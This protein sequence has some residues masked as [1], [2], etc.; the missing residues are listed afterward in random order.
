[1]QLNSHS[2]TLS[3]LSCCTPAHASPDDR[4]GLRTLL[5]QIA[6]RSQNVTVKGRIQ[7]VKGCKACERPT[8]NRHTATKLST[9]RSTPGP[10]ANASLSPHRYDADADVVVTPLGLVLQVSQQVNR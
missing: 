2:A 5:S 9:A 1:M 10:P 7:R 8:P 4:H 6:H 3:Q